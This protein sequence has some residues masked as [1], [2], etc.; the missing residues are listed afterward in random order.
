MEDVRAMP[1]IALTDLM[2]YFDAVRVVTR[3]YL[4]HA[5]DA[6]L[7]WEYQHPLLGS[8]TGT[9]IVG[10]ILVEE[11]Q[12]VGQITLLRNMIRGVGA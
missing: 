12:H 2:A 5:T 9:W 8:L 7:V 6:D 4:A 3:H 11:S 1:E 10:H